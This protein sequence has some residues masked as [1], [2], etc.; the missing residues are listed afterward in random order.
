MHKLI[1]GR[2]E[3]MVQDIRS[4]D[5]RKKDAEDAEEL[6]RQ[7]PPKTR[8]IGRQRINDINKNNISSNNKNNKITILNN[9]I[10]NQLVL[11]RFSLLVV[12]IVIFIV[13][14]TPLKICLTIMP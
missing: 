6:L 9:K 1:Q 12:S 8:K 3:V 5:Q 13:L 11:P 7:I 14:I 10:Y 2:Y 4:G